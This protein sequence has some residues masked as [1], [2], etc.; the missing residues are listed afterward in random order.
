MRTIKYLATRSSIRAFSAVSPPPRRAS[1]GML[2]S[3]PTGSMS[4]QSPSSPAS[5][6]EDLDDDRPTFTSGLRQMNGSSAVFAAKAFSVATGVVILG[7]LGAVWTFKSICGFHDARQISEYI[8]TSIS[9]VSSKS[10]S[11]VPPD[12]KIRDES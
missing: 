4:R 11:L 1:L 8:R 10:V 2:P 5:A 3:I 9:S 6:E 7:G 12:P